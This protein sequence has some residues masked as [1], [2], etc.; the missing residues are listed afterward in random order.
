MEFINIY[1]YTVGIKLDERGSIIEPEL[2][3]S[4]EQWIETGDG[5]VKKGF[6]KFLNE[7]VEQYKNHPAWRIKINT[8]GAVTTVKLFFIEEIWEKMLKE[9]RDKL[10]IDPTEE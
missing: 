4:M 8:K 5:I 3:D 9:E 2:P 6:E 10:H 7:D 1:K